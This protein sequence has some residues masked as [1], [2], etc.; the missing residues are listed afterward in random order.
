MKQ[1]KKI[2]L[3]LVLAL[4][5]ISVNNS[6]YNVSFAEENEEREYDKVYL[7][8]LNKTVYVKKGLDVSRD[9]LLDI[10]SLSEGEEIRIYNV[11][12][13]EK[14]K[15]INKTNYEPMGRR[16]HVIRN[17]FIRNINRNKKV[18]A[19]VGRGS[20]YTLN[21]TI[22]FKQ[23]NVIYGSAEVNILSIAKA[24]ISANYGNGLSVSVSVGTKF[25]GPSE[26]SKYNSRTYYSAIKTRIGY[27]N[28]KKVGEPNSKFRKVN[29]EVPIQRVE[30]SEDSSI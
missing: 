29:Y 23:N 5:T 2:V 9:T 25:N 1:I 17:V 12:N 18:L 10:A 4:G 16:T 27:L 26:N 11:V 7:E 8:E 15:H 19:T 6:F 30:W 22:T 14:K 24:N 3:L 20:S 13:S 21:R 28:I